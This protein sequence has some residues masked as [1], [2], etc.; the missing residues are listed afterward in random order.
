MPE[1]RKEERKTDSLVDRR[2]PGCNGTERIGRNGQIE[3]NGDWELENI[4]DIKKP[5]L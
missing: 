1:G 5:I 2:K 4:S 3:K